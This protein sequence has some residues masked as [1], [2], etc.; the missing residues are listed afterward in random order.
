MA[1]T[2][3]LYGGFFTA[4]CNK[5]IDW[6]SDTIKAMMT[7]ASYTPNQDT[8]DYK[9]DVTNEVSGT[10]YSAG[11]ATLANCT[12]TYTGAT[13]KLKLDADDASWSSSTITLPISGSVIVYD[14]S[15]GSDSTRPLVCYMT[16]DTAVAS[17]AGTFTVAWHAD[18]IV[19]I[20]LA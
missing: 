1:V 11:G 19:E 15:P 5:E 6:N 2:A 7:T 12:I 18:G 3:K 14:S 4:L 9:D 16:T 13:N 10:G 8:H 20:T 17:T